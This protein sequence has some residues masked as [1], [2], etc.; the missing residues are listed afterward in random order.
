MERNDRLPNPTQLQFLA[1]M[2]TDELPGRDIAKRL[3]KES[4]RAIGYG[5]LYVT[6]QRLRDEGWVA[7]SDTSDVDGRVRIFRVTGAGARAVARAR[8]FHEGLAVFG[9]NPRTAT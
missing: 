7:Y 1:V 6:L 3:K 8:S 9:L 5:T 4:G 2:G